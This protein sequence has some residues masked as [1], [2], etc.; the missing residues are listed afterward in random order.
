M[1]KNDPNFET[2]YVDPLFHEAVPAEIAYKESQGKVLIIEDL[3]KK[4]KDGTKAVNG[5][6][7]KMYS[8]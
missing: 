8:D 5:I 2:K 3:T 7:L 6:N 1:G 4:Y